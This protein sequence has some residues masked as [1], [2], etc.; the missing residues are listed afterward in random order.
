MTQCL[1]NTHQTP[2]L[3]LLQSIMEPMLDLV[4][5]NRN[6]NPSI[7]MKTMIT[8]TRVPTTPQTY[9]LFTSY[10]T[11]WYDKILSL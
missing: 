10:V 8:M 9:K 5:E 11:L 7:R 4:Y 3:M 1:H 6:R 2:S